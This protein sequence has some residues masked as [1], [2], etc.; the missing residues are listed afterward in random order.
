MFIMNYLN[1]V[2]DTVMQPTFKK[3]KTVDIP[4]V[5]DL[6]VRFTCKI[7]VFRRSMHFSSCNIFKCNY[8]QKK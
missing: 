4:N 5:K 1:F 8:S 7:A 6:K 3:K 2:T